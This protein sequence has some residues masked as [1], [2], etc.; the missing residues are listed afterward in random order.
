MRILTA[1]R[2][3]VAWLGCVL[4]CLGFQQ[5]PAPAPAAKSKPKDPPAS[6][7]GRVLNAASGEPVK[8]ATLMMVR[9][10]GGA[11]PVTTE[12][13]DNGHFIFQELAPGRYMLIGERAGFA[14]QAY[15]ARTNPFAGMPLLFSS[16]QEIKELVF[17]LSPSAVIA[18]R[19]TDDEGEPIPNVTVMAL[20]TMYQRGRKQFAPLGAA[21]TNDVGEF[22]IASLKSG[23]YIVSATYRNLGVTM[24][25]TS[26][27]PPAAD[28]PE[29]SFTTTFYPGA[30]DPAGASPIEVGVG[31][32]IRADIRMVKVNTFRVRGKL[33]EVPQGKPIIVTM[34]PAGSG[35][36]GMITRSM[37]LAQQTDGTFEIKGVAPGSYLLSATGTDMV[38]IGA[39]RPLQVTDQHI[40]GIVLEAGA[41]GDLPGTLTVESKDPVD[42]K[43]LQVTLE[44]IDVVSLGLKAPVAED[45]KFT[46]KNV[47]PGRYRVNFNNDPPTSYVLSMRHG[48]T[49]IVEDGVDLTGGVTGSLQIVL[50]L[51]GGQV[52]GTV[53]GADDQPLSGATVALI[54]VSKRPSFYREN[55]SDQHGAFSFKGIKP[56][57]YEVLAW[58]EIEQGAYQDPE[59]LKPFESKAE[60]VSVKENDRKALS[61]KAIPAAQ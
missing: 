34:T 2:L 31:A 15:G 22:R 3:A 12:S 60:A 36:T 9:T 49:D 35:V 32:E 57:D 38:T 61:L 18:G 42:L 10:G 4:F 39:V 50:S 33:A 24:A 8:K 19:V 26:S 54:P 17:K 47:T 7:E 6:L 43:D 44:P 30:I 53:Q 55:I 56:G 40:E 1:S 28:K 11:A 21:Q 37:G 29:P 51:A 27:K 58:E 13:D 5:A 46:L 41:G 52:E 23:R 20:R 16:G 45:G 14:R 59:F 25:G 48:T